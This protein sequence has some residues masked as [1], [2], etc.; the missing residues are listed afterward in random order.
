MSFQIPMRPRDLPKRL[1]DIRAFI[2]QPKYDGW[3]VVFADRRAYTR[4]GEDIT[5]WACWS[6][7]QLPV[8]AVGELMHTGGR[9]RIPSLANAAEGLR[10]VLF[11]SPGCEAI[12]WRLTWMHG[13][14]Y[15]HGFESAPFFSV[16]SWVE[17]NGALAGAQAAPLVEGLVLKRRGSAWTPGEKHHDWYRFKAPVTIGG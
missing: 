8:N 14:A 6:G 7:R 4:T 15:K 12:E 10:V 17:A 2:L 9:H 3:Y 16:D 13:R 5:G 11:D 1:P